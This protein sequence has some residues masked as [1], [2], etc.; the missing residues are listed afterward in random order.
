MLNTAQLNQRTLKTAIHCHGIGLHGG[1]LVR[2][3]LRPAAIESGITFIRTD[4]GSHGVVQ[5][6]YDAVV[7]TKLCT[8]LGNSA[9]A[10]VGTVEHLLAAFSGC[11]ID[12]AEV[13]LDA[14]E[15]PILDGSSEPWVFLI[16][17]AGIQAQNAPRRALRVL[18]QVSVSEGAASA[19]FTPAQISAFA[20]EIDFDADAIG[21]QRYRL[22]LN[23]GAFGRELANCRTFCRLSDV[24]SLRAIGLAQGGSLEN[25]VVV[26]GS[27]I[28]NPEGLRR[29]DEF[30]R[31]KMLDAVG[32]LYLAGGPILAQYHG[33]KAGHK[34]NN[35]LLRAVFADAR[36]YEWVD[37]DAASLQPLTQ[38]VVRMANAAVL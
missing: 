32:D 9:G 23:S 22:T 17:S 15:V 19:V 18:R 31:H 2:L 36:N 24:E 1:Q 21:R 29:P 10:L 4:L 20:F 35:M 11:G 3:E 26:D 12:N 34:L 6:R 30:V 27:K 8:V 28:L 16:Q 25:A 33:H 7:D 14:A 37:L 38:P 5:A 13:H